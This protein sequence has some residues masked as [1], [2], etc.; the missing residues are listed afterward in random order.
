MKQFTTER[1]LSV[2]DIPSP[3]C[4]T[5]FQNWNDSNAK[6]SDCPKFTYF[7]YSFYSDKNK[8]TKKY[9]S[10][11]RML[12]VHKCQ[13][14]RWIIFSIAI[15]RQLSA[16]LMQASAFLVRHL[17][18]VWWRCRSHREF[19]ASNDDWLTWLRLF[20]GIAFYLRKKLFLYNCY[21]WPDPIL[22]DSIHQTQIT[23]N[24]AYI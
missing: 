20:V 10:V 21:F 11:D 23:L 4:P 18:C 15:H 17:F 7:L 2:L 22:V 14:L 16:D 24:P 19:R 8:H 1:L 13:M 3:W 5:F 9:V 12:C 6:K